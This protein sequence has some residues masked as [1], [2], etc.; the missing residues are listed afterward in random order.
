MSDCYTIDSCKA[1]AAIKTDRPTAG[2]LGRSNVIIGSRPLVY[3]HWLQ[4]AIRR[5]AGT[6]TGTQTAAAGKRY[7]LRLAAG[8]RRP[9]PRPTDSELDQMLS[10]RRG[11][12]TKKPE[13]ERCEGLKTQCIHELNRQIEITFGF[14]HE[15]RMS[16]GSI[17]I[18]LALGPITFALES[19]QIYYSASAL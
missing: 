6:Q 3:C 4:Y 5:Q 9:V 10:H 2:L 17:R 11:N 12:F 8:V 19:H 16:K 14:L 13:N 18:R 15:W 7:A 1:R